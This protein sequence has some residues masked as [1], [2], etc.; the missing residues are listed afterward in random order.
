M[1]EAARLAHE[2][3]FSKYLVA[4]CWPKMKRRI[5]SWSSRGYIYELSKIPETGLKG[6]VSISAG[7]I[8]TSF[9]DRHNDDLVELVDEMVQDGEMERVIMR[10]SGHSEWDFTLITSSGSCTY[11][12]TTCFIF[13]QLLISTLRAYGIALRALAKAQRTA[14]AKNVVGEKVKRMKHLVEKSNNVWICGILLSKIA[15]SRMLRQ[16]LMA[17]RGFLH[18]PTYGFRDDYKTFSTQE[19]GDGSNWNNV[20]DLDES[21]VED[22]DLRGDEELD[23]VFLNWVR[24]QASYWLNLSTLS[25]RFGSSNPTY[26][27]PE[28]FL[29][30]MKHPMDLFGPFIVEEQKDT[31]KTIIGS[32]PS[33]P[34]DIEEVLAK[35]KNGGG[36]NLYPPNIHCEAA[37]AVLILLA[38][39]LSAAEAMELGPVIELLQVMFNASSSSPSI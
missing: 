8:S 36:E 17:C 18:I 28:I 11:D 21:A 4:R 37:L 29:L 2:E 3:Y 35:V 31:L 26:P 7:K 27:V 6:R 24:L 33:H 38:H 16:H 13:H 32:D 12:V 15:S 9:T 20:N 34:I 5:D 23:E 22:L 1:Q 25:R 39:H 30:A 14:E 19:D 10:P